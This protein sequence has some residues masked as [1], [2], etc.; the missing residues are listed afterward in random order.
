MFAMFGVGGVG[1]DSDVYN[2]YVYTTL[3]AALP[4]AHIPPEPCAHVDMASKRVRGGWDGDADG[5]QLV[6][7][8]SHRLSSGRITRGLSEA[9]RWRSAI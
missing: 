2:G 6:A 4:R 3:T 9:R 1:S 5:I 8:F 7:R